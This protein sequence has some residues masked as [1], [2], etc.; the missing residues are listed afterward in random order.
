MENKNTQH[1]EDDF[2]RNLVKKSATSQPSDGFTN[3]LMKIFCPYRVHCDCNAGQKIFCPY[4]T[5]TTLLI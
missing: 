4:R 3:N 1:I 2:L 5:I